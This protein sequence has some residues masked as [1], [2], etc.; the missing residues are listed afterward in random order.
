MNEQPPSRPPREIGAKNEPSLTDAVLGW[1]RRFARVRDGDDSARDTLEEIIE[2]RGEAEGSIGKDQRILLANILELRGRTVSDVMVPRADIIAVSRDSSLAEVIELTTKKSHSRLPVYGETLDD[3]T[4]MVH[5]KDVP[6][7][8]G[9]DSNALG[10]LVSALAGR[11]P[12]CGELV[13]HPSG[14][15]FEIIDADSH[16]IKRLR[17]HKPARSRRRDPKG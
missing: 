1:I 17:L 13:R 9:E 4:G 8:R 11:V 16:H 14:Y 2:E 3:V 6:A 15:E 7:W 12:I 10:G 5:I